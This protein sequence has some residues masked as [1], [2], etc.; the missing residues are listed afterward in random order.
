M[1][2]ILVAPAS[3][4]VYAGEAPGLLAAELR[5]LLTAAGHDPGPIRPLEL[6]GVH[7]LE[8]D[9]DAG[10]PGAD[11]TRAR[12]ELGR[13]S[14]V[15]AAYERVGELLRP[16]PLVRPDRFEDDLVTIP[17]Y[18]GKT[19]EQFTRLLL[20]VTLAARQRPRPGPASVLDPLSG[21]GTTL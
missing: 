6:A 10:G 3:N 11:D 8:L 9:L 4:R 13:A 1:F 19:N 2:L 16:V 18:A 7:Y 12:A 20:D 17:K 21:R 5:V 15:L 14:A